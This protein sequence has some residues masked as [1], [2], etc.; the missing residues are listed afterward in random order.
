MRTW[1][2]SCL[3]LTIIFTAGCA[4]TPG[5][6]DPHDPLESYNRAMY[7]FNQGFDDSIAKPVAKAYQ[8]VTPTWMDK[9]ITNFFS[10]LD[11]VVVLCN[12]LLQL[13]FA[14]AAS[15]TARIVFNTTAGLLGFVD[16]A[17]HMDLPKHHEDFGQTLGYWGMPPGPYFVL[18]FLGP[19]T[20]RDSAGLGTDYVFFDPVTNRVSKKTTRYGLL[21]VDF[22]D[23]RAD[24]LKASRLLDE[25][26][27]DPYVYTRE[28]YLQRRRYFVYDGDPPM[29]DFDQ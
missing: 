19:S 16:V 9:G 13:K 22:I 18:P 10:N 27:L 6:A 2:L 11:D 28:A 17:S 26:A 29:E 4:S 5:P 20:I 8:K 3:S 1:F 21:V 15:D 7:R 23:T 12:D 24:L 14:Q 25:A